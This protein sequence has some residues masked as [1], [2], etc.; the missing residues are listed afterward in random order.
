MEEIEVK[1]LEIN[2][3]QIQKK[4]VALGA[5][6]IADHI[7]EAVFYDFPDRSLR[8]RHDVVRLRTEDKTAILAFKK[9]RP[10]TDVKV[11]EEYEVQVSNSRETEKILQGIGLVPYKYTKKRRVS[12]VVDKAHFEIDTYLGEHTCIPAFLEIEAPSVKTIEKYAK[13]LGFSKKDLKPWSFEQLR[14]H[15]NRRQK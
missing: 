1:I 4:L 14:K 2:P 9:F 8:E 5:K 11:R 6:K 15:Y 7:L 13:M 10:S 3:S 12:Y